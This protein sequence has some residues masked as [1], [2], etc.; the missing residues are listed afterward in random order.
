MKIYMATVAFA[1]SNLVSALKIDARNDAANVDGGVQ[2]FGPIFD[3]GDNLAQDKGAI[4]S[5][6]QQMLLAQDD[7]AGFTTPMVPVE[8][9]DDMLAESFSIAE[10]EETETA[11]HDE[12]AQKDDPKAENYKKW[13]KFEPAYSHPVLDA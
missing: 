5:T 11:M 13:L 12:L 3:Y 6:D 9:T 8:Q 7:F 4:I 1:C 10:Q 2:T